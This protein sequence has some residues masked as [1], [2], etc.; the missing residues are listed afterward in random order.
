MKVVQLRVLDI[1][2]IDFIKKFMLVFDVEHLKEVNGKSCW[3]T[4]TNDNIL[5]IEPLHKKDGEVF[6]LE[7][8]SKQ[9]KHQKVL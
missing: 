4:H 3:V 2:N 9:W 8:W 1:I 5:K 6:N 7:E